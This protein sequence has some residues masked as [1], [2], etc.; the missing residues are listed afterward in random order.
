[1]KQKK[2]KLKDTGL[3]TEYEAPGLKVSFWQW[4][5]A[6]WK[7]YTVVIATPEKHYRIMWLRGR[8]RMTT[9]RPEIRGVSYGMVRMDDEPQGEGRE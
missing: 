1:M 7:G 2:V 8:M 3:E 6:Y 9:E 5:I 4:I